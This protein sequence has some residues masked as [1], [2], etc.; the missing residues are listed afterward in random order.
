MQRKSGFTLIEVLV[1]MVVIV[2]LASALVVIVVGIFDRAKV[3]KT[4]ALIHTLDTGCNTYAALFK[5]F[6]P[7]TPYTGSQN[8]HYYLGRECTILEQVDPPI[9]KKHPRIV[10]FRPDWLT[11]PA[12]VDPNPPVALWDTWGSLIEYDSIPAGNQT[13]PSKIMIRSRGPDKTANSGDEV[14]NQNKEF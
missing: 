10:E 6:P 3:E 9:R 8:L 13:N 4:A 7:F 11:N 14:D 12:Q 2:V 5:T 1:V